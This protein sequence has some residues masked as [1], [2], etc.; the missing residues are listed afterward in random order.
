MVLEAV[1]SVAAGA[2]DGTVDAESTP[3]S[4]AANDDVKAHGDEDNTVA[5][6]DD[7]EDVEAED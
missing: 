3:P 7:P 4:H 5:E 1:V 2:A 6:D